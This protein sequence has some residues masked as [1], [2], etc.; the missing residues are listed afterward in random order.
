M[1][2]KIGLFAI[3]NFIAMFA[4]AIFIAVSFFVFSI[5]GMGLAKTFGDAKG[6]VIV[7]D[8]DKV[9]IGNVMNYTDEDYV[10]LIEAR[11]FVQQEEIVNVALERSRNEKVIEEVL[12]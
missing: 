9:E 4:F 2:N 6:G 1:K 12:A 8:E 10:D 3:G 11:F 5:Y 7:Y